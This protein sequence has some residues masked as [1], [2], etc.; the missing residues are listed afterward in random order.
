VYNETPLYD[1]SAGKGRVNTSCALQLGIRRA[2]AQLA[3]TARGVVA[4]SGGPDS[5]ALLR[6]LLDVGMPLVL[7]HVNHR[8]RGD[9]SDGDE[10]F[11]RRLHERCMAEGAVELQLRVQGLDTRV[12]AAGDNLESAARRLRYEWLTTV[13]QQTGATWVATGH[14]ADDQAETVLHR[15]LRGTG[16]RGLAGIPARRELVQ[17]VVLLRPL[18]H[19]RRN[20]VLTFLEQRGQDY[21]RDSSNE[22]RQYTRNALRHEVL[23][24]L[25]RE[26]N[27]AIV[28]VLGRLSQQANEVQQFMEE[29]ATQLLTAAE[30]PR[31]GAVVVLDA[32]RL[33]GVSPV[34]LREVVRW[35]W[36]REGWALRDVDF[37]AWERAASVVRG[38][39]AAVDLPGGVRVRRVRHVVQFSVT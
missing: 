3:P 37:A 12:L 9:E 20:E 32:R 31:A 19:V 34:L 36:R 5:V 39:A 17:G 26:F 27:P 11:V 1:F 15:L 23:P 10:A 25:A 30:L 8:L 4:V 6:A 16:L 22:D 13:A 29:Q 33:T 7:A 2:L 21:C 28:D 14:T 35:L 24:L 38:E 18:L